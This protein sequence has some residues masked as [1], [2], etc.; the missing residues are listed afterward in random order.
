MDQGKVIIIG[1]T[2]RRF[3]AEL[4]K[5]AKSDD[6]LRRCMAASASQ[7]PVDVLQQLCDDPEP[8]VRWCV[9]RNT[10]LTSKMQNLPY[11]E[12]ADKRTNYTITYK[13]S[14]EKGGVYWAELEVSKAK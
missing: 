8:L 13:F 10:I 12:F 6:L 4:E 3:V 2:K 1:N 9:L 14:Q 7:T 5:A 11:E